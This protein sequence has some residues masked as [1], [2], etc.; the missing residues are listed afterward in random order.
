MEESLDL[1]FLEILI[2]HYKTYLKNNDGIPQTVPND[3]IKNIENLRQQDGTYR[4]DKNYLKPGDQVLII[5]GVMT[6]IKGVLN[7]YIDEK[8]I[9]GPI[10][11]NKH[12][13]ICKTRNRRHK[14]KYDKQNLIICL[15]ECIHKA[16]L[17]FCL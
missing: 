7:E 6:G 15:Q 10:T 3:I 11:R 9:R 14:Y 13:W 8:N 4:F 1:D 17:G 2:C 5:D 16:L 12:M